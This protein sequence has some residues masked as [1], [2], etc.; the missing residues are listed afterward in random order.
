MLTFFRARLIS[1]RNFKGGIVRKGLFVLLV[2]LGTSVSAATSGTYD[3]G[4]NRQGFGYCYEFARNGKVLNGGR[5]VA[6]DNCEAINPSFFDWAR[7]VYGYGECYQ[8][9]PYGHVMN[10]GMAQEQDNCEAVSPSFYRWA[11]AN[12]GFTYCFH[13]TRNGLV[14]DNGQPAN[15]EMCYLNKSK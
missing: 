4:S 13:F 6:A 1:L 7:S 10:T 3:W 14:L 15:P 8:F 9:T 2:L 5:P 12:D 11:R